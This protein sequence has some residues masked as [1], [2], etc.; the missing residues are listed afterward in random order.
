MSIATFTRVETK[1]TR[2]GDI[3]GYWTMRAGDTAQPLLCPRYS[4]KS[5]HIMGT[6]DGGSITLKGSNDD[7][8]DPLNF[9]DIYD[10]EGTTITQAAAR[11]PWVI[12]PNVYALMPVLTG[13]GGSTLLKI[14][15]VGRGDLS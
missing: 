1:G 8:L 7:L 13:G 4:D 2:V 9:D 5:L 10:F 6:F 12:L 3:L 11:K 15:L 14:A